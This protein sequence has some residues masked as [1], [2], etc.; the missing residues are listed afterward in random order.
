MTYCDVS[1]SNKLSLI[2][3]IFGIFLVLLDNF[4]LN[5]LLM[6]FYGLR[7]SMEENPYSFSFAMDNETNSIA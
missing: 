4:V 2:D 6:E 3:L 7:E 1:S 5:P